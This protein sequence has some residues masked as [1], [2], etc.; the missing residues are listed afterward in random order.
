MNKIKT[1]LSAISF[2]IIFSCNETQENKSIEGLWL[3][4]SVKMGDKE[5]T[6]I[7]R[8]MRF[9]SDSTQTSGN[10][11]LQHSIGTWSLNSNNDLSVINT[12]GIID[13]VE[14]FK[15]VMTQTNMTWKRKEDGMDVTVFLERTNKLPVSEGNKLMGL[16]K[17]NQDNSQNQSYKIK[18][19]YISWD[20]RFIK[21]FESNKKEYG[22]YKIHGHKPEIQM[23]NYGNTPQFKYY[24]FNF[25]SENLILKSTDN[26]EEFKLNRIH[27]FLK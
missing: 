5:M 6:P 11:W 16:W 20:N 9:N 21:E 7:A 25:D 8:W 18:T 10:G 19:L 4:K 1:L 24:K 22:I 26:Q 2:I 15:V 14:P 23:V 17:L 27:Q 12:N 3:V 13:E